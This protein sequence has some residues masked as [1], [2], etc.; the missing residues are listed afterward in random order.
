MFGAQRS[1]KNGVIEVNQR[2]AKLTPIMLRAFRFRFE[3]FG[4]PS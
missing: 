3:E 4:V 1:S 2:L